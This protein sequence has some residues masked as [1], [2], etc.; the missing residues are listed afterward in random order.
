MKPEQSHEPE[1]PAGS[2]A[3]PPRFPDYPVN[4]HEKAERDLLHRRIAEEKA[5]YERGFPVA[6]HDFPREHRER[7]RGR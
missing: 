2:D 7:E 3:R 5:H 6:G 4:E 1:R